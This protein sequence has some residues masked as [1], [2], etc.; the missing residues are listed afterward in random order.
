VQRLAGDAR[1][2]DTTQRIPHPYEDGMAEEWIDSHE[3]AF[4]DKSQVVF[5]ITIRENKTVVGAI[6][7]TV[8]AAVSEA[9]LGYWIGVPFWKKGIATEA[10]AAILD[11]GFSKLHLS[12]ISGWYLLR[13]PSSGRVMQKAG[14]R[15]DEHSRRKIKKDGREESLTSCSLLR[16]EWESQQARTASGRNQPA[17]RFEL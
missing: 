4:L 15:K 3:T 12:K 9:E 2:A 1:V 10:T 17:S 7:L 11:Y 14:M 5:A 6:G 8:S 16:D 13:N